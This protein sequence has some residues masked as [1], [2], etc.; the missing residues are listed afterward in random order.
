MAVQNEFHI[1]PPADERAEALVAGELQMLRHEVG[2]L[3]VTLRWSEY[4]ELVGLEQHGLL[5][6]EML[7]SASTT[8]GFSSSITC[9]SGRPRDD[10]QHPYDTPPKREIPALLSDVVRS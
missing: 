1:N 4:R 8:C 6:D 5:K 10:C 3:A 9:I 2:G 7:Q